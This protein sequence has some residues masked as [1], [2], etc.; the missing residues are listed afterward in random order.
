MLECNLFILFGF[1]LTSHTLICFFQLLFFFVT[2]TC[3]HSKLPFFSLLRTS[4]ICIL[5]HYR[6]DYIA[7]YS[8][9]WRDTLCSH[10]IVVDTDLRV[11]K[12]I[13]G[14]WTLQHQAIMI[15]VK[16]SEF[17]EQLEPGAVAEVNI[18]AQ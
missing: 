6:C 7:L 2:S 5:D 11:P 10:R 14:G 4:S 15:V 9:N 17:V 1:F 13:L 8:C 12:I 16:Q 18:Y 3:S